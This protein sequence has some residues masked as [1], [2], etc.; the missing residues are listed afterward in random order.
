M[1]KQ[2]KLHI[3]WVLLM[4]FVATASAAEGNVQA[5]SPD[6]GLKDLFTWL[7]QMGAIFGVL[8]FLILF[9]SLGVSIWITTGLLKIQRSFWACVGAGVLGMVF[10]IAGLALLA[11]AIEQWKEYEGVI[12]LAVWTILIALSIWI[13]LRPSIGRAFL[14]SII[15]QILFIVVVIAVVL[16]LSQ[17]VPRMHISVPPN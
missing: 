2:F 16:L 4:L 5:V 11:P 9:G 15:S 13:A 3:S 14:A 17:I 12:Q 1:I 8:L 7:F 10:G 6:N